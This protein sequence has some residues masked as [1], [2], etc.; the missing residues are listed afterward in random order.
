MHNC[1][2]LNRNVSP[3]LQEMF[4][5]TGGFLL[6]KVKFPLEMMSYSLWYMLKFQEYTSSLQISGS[7]SGIISTDWGYVMTRLTFTVYVIL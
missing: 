4:C 5:S 1:T 7:I 2:S 6:D 3:L